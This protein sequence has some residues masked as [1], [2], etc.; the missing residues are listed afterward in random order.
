MT[1]GNTPEPEENPV[2]EP[3]TAKP[4][5]AK[6]D[7]ASDAKKGPSGAKKAFAA[8]T[9]SLAVV[10]KL[11]GQAIWI[12]CVL[13][14]LALAVGALLVALEA[15][16]KNTAVSFILET[17][18]QAD[19]GLFNHDGTG[20]FSFQGENMV[21]KNALVNWGIGAVAWLIVG[22]IAEKIIRP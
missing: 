8:G 18:D 16:D 9:A 2:T 19:L 11:L 4:E 3:D 6:P 1:S 10:R 5:T 17:A 20:P 12:V 15:N 21:T 7:A 14:A 22:K 13:A